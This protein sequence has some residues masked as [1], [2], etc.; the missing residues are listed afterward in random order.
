MKIHCKY[1]PVVID[2]LYDNV[3][4]ANW[5]KY[6]GDSLNNFAADTYEVLERRIMDLP[7]KLQER[8]PRMIADNFLI[9][10]GTDDGL[11]FALS[12][13]D[14]WTKFPSDFVRAA[15]QLK[16]EWELFENEFNIFFPEVFDMAS[17]FCDC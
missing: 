2:I 12:M 16:D 14:R 15:A 11:Q 6:H 1:A 4:V 3:L 17:E 13:M 7:L 8:V 9:R 10:Y 5:S